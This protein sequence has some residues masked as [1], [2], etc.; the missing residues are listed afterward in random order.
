MLSAS[1]RAVCL[2]LNSLWN[3]TPITTEKRDAARATSRACT[4]MRHRLS[5]SRCH[6]RPASCHA[7]RVAAVDSRDASVISRLPLRPSRAGTRMNSS[8]ISVNSGQCCTTS[9]KMPAATIPNPATNRDGNVCTA[10]EHMND[11]ND[12]GGFATTIGGVLARLPPCQEAL[13]PPLETSTSSMASAPSGGPRSFEGDVGVGNRPLS[14]SAA[15]SGAIDPGSGDPMVVVDGP[16]LT[17]V[18]KSCQRPRVAL[19]ATV[20]MM[21]QPCL[22][23][24]DSASGLA[25]AIPRHA[26]AATFPEMSPRFTPPAANRTAL[27]TRCCGLEAAVR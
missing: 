1:S 16:L 25:Q 15:S 26:S 3:T 11:A 8:L 22:R 21:M 7:G 6:R 27:L 9:R 12:A 18:G 19:C 2:A 10:N 24:A 4:W 23:L 17:R 5:A 13:P 14:A 20:T